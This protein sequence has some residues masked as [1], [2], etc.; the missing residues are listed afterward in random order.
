M[1]SEK[2]W[3]QR[4]LAGDKAAFAQLVEAYQAP[5]YNLAYRILGDAAEAEDAAQETFVR[6]YTRLHTYEPEKKLSSWILSIASHYCIDCLRRRRTGNVDLEDILAQ[7][8][9]ADPGE[10]PEKAALRKETC[11]L[12]RDLMRELPGP[13]RLVL[14]LRYW[15]D[16]SYEEMAEMLGTTE[17]AIKSRLH[18][19]RCL[20]AERIA[21]LENRSN[22][23][24][25][26]QSLPPSHRAEEV[27]QSALSASH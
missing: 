13:Y 18:R 3:V 24:P 25:S 11:D 12:V 21:A 15:H 8:A 19:A 2:A 23:R 14:T 4:A 16:F 5:V 26:S 20:L 1:D 9:F 27:M 22:A 10:G 17:S 7:Q 6:I